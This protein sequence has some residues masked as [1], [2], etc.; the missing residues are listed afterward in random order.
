MNRRRKLWKAVCL[1]VGVPGLLLP[2]LTVGAIIGVASFLF[3]AT[4]KALG[5][6]WAK[7]FPG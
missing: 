4:T 6:S 5:D 7:A 1:L 2:L 3:D